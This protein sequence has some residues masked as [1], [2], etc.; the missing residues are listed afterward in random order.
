MEE[1]GLSETLL[2]AYQGKQRRSR[3]KAVHNKSYISSRIL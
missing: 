3:R 2:I 1:A